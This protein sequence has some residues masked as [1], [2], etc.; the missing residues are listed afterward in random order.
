V[1]IGELTAP[2]QRVLGCLIEKRWTTPD[3]F[4]LSLNAL[5][6]ACNQSTNRDPVTDYDDHTVRQAA[7]RLSRYGLA[8]LASGPGS[9]AI[10]YRHLA[11]DALGL[12]R[13][14][15]AVLAVL[16]LRGSQ[17]PGE[18]KTRADRLA[19]LES[20]GDVERVL[21]ILVERGYATRLGRRPGQKEDRFEHQLGP[22]APEDSD[23][24]PP[25]RADP[26]Q[27]AVDGWL[28]ARVE[29]LEQEVA[30]LREQLAEL[31]DDRRAQTAGLPPR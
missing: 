21:G 4:P 2:E 27:P 22:G 17:T 20:L 14:E 29:V 28:E 12:G 26:P 15:L 11:E 1:H 3:Q 10:K 23:V 9:R 5:R 13:E 19:S 6:Q 24:V 8:R 30:E 16:L 25:V 31:R 18:L 7:E